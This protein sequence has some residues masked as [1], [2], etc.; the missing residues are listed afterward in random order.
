MA[1]NLYMSKARYCQ[2]WQ[3]PKILWLLQNKPEERET[4]SSAESRMQTGIE[5]GELAKSMFGPYVDVST[6]DGER[7]DL[8]RMIQYSRNLRG[9]LCLRQ[10]L[11]RRG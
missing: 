5:V 2:L 7:L 10:S 9:V 1:S 3:C 8:Q 6:R 11:L 4:D